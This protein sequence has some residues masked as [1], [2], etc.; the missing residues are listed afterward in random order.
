MPIPVENPSFDNI[1]MTEVFCN[2]VMTTVHWMP[3]DPHLDVRRDLR[4]AL[5]TGASMQ[6]SIRHA[7]TKTFAIFCAQG[8]VATAAG[9]AVPTLLHTPGRVVPGVAI[10]LAAA[11]L[12][13]LTTTTWHLG[14]ALVPRLTGPAGR[15]RFAFPNIAAASRRPGRGDTRRQ[16]DEAWDLVSTLAWIVLTKHRHVRRSLPWF[17]GAVA[18]AAGLHI[19][20][21]LIP[22]SG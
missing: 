4:L 6:A 16:R 7:D 20:A 5:R 2:Q 22:P 12:C 21:S 19:L 15:N 18:A 14:L 8:G 13:A 3:P 10:L 17:G 11:T 9:Q 1:L